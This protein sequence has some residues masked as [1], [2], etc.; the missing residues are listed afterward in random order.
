MAMKTWLFF[1][2]SS[3]LLFSC[4][5]DE[6]REY[7]EHFQ[8]TTKEQENPDD[9]QCPSLEEARRRWLGIG[10]GEGDTIIQF[11][12]GPLKKPRSSSDLNC[13]YQVIVKDG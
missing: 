12:S 13:C 7:C 3:V 11:K 5:G 2:L 1:L 8:L 9:Y 10:L 4:S 6:E